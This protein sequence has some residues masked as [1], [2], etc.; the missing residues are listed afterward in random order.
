MLSTMPRP[1]ST[2][3]TA[4]PRLSLD[5]EWQFQ[6]GKDAAAQTIAVPSPWEAAIPALRGKAGTAAYQRTFTVPASFQGK[7]VLLHF[8]AADYFTE[9]WVNGVAVGTHEGGYTPF[10]FPIEAALKSGEGAEQTLLVRVTD[11]TLTEDATLP[12]GDALPFAE[13]PHGKQSWYTSIGGLWQSV[14]LEARN[15]THV[16]RVVFLPDIDAGVANVEIRVAGSEAGNREGWRARIV[17]DAPKGAAAVES[18]VLPLTQGRDENGVLTLTAALPIPNAAL[19]HPDA[20]NLYHA[21]VTLE[22]DGEVEDAAATRFGM[23]KV[24][25]KSGHVWLNNQPYFLI[26]ALDQAFYPQTIYTPPSEEYLRDQFVKAR[27]MGLNLMRCHIKVPTP[28]YLELCDEIGLLVWYEIPNG[29]KL[30]LPFR[31]RARQTLTD[32]WERDANH[33]CLIIATIIN[34]SWGI[35]LHDPEQRIWM[36]DTYRWAKTLCP[37][38]LIVDNSACLVN[39]HLESDLDDY[40]MYF[41][42]PD[43]SAK[44]AE[45]IAKFAERRAGTYSAYGDGVYRG[46]EPLLLSEFGNWGL[47]RVDKVFEAEGGEPYWFKTGGSGDTR[48]ENVLKR[49]ENQKLSRAF[50]DYNALADASQEQE[51]ISL[52]W[53]IEEM[54]RHSSL[55]GYVITELT[56]INWECNGLL[57]MGRNPKTFHHRIKDV[58][59][60]DILIPRLAPR[61]ALWT[62]ETAVLALEFSCFSG[63]SAAGGAVEWRSAEIEGLNGSQTVK[64]DSQTEQETEIGTYAI[65]QIWITAP[66]VAA[67]TKTTIEITLRGAAGDVLARTTQNLVIVPAA[68]RSLAETT[69][70]LHDPLEC[71]IGLSALLT[72]IGCRV[73]AEPEAGA[74]A[75]A[76]CWDAA[77]GD[78]T[79]A[80]GKSVLI[81]TDDRSLT[82]SSGLGLS[83]QPRSANG[84]WGDWCSSKTWFAAE[85]FPA[86]PDRD[87][88]D[89]E[90]QSVVPKRVLTGPLPDNILAGL[91]IGW[92]RSP[93][94]LVARLPVGAG[95][96]V[97][98]TFEILPRVGSD[99]IA[100]LLLRDLLEM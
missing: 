74:T 59:A 76:T 2:T 89:F 53:E 51:Y 75:L 92:L 61:T 1:D 21:L 58:Q 4:R 68:S 45:W 44:F 60:Q 47:P 52:K 80:G 57:D 41:N 72:E 42:I 81:A 95:S 63:K 35:D 84:W 88:F 25:T 54:R 20:P 16:G 64:F 48:P 32:M 5:G 91:F 71:A 26:G 46:N 98:S 67:T 3:E 87:R 65:G 13:I 39:Y 86:L 22:R 17:I 23:R 55:S 19:W 56:D 99:P 15:K 100:T 83:L 93:A 11:A 73:V 50:P 37:S 10:A 24:E 69:V 94:A 6:F 78:F 79:R 33:P 31:D 62:G 36:R 34:E 77:L 66:N 49:F 7:T 43:Q 38:W 30:S 14:Y 18:L 28:S 96:L 9:V 29:A 90:F 70:W 97:I 12:N 82:S 27:E 8:G 40:H 85:H